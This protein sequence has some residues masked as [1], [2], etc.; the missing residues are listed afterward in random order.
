MVSV[1]N[2][3]EY[4]VAMFF[5]LLT[6]WS[7]ALI[8][9]LNSG[10]AIAKKSTMKAFFKQVVGVP[11]AP[12]VIILQTGFTGPIVSR[13][14]WISFRV[15]R[16]QLSSILKAGKYKVSNKATKDQLVDEFR[17]LNPPSWWWPQHISVTQPVT[18][19]EHLES[20]IK[21]DWGTWRYLVV[22][23]ANDIVSAVYYTN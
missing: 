5:R 11:A 4:G 2:L 1:A 22:N 14:Q 20:S 6:F 19:Y 18:V 10:C 8:M 17:S 21:D 15:T 12:T 23:P 9:V 7:V 3:T 13:A 16:N